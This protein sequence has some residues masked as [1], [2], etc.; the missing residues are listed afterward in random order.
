MRR[1]FKLTH[2]KDAGAEIDTE[3]LL[4]VGNGGVEPPGRELHRREKEQLTLKSK[5]LTLKS[6][7]LTLKSKA[8][9][10]FCTSKKLKLTFALFASAFAIFLFVKP[11][12]TEM[13]WGHHLQ[14]QQISNINLRN[15]TFAIVLATK[16]DRPLSAMLKHYGNECS[17]VPISTIFI[18]GGGSS[19]SS[20]G[21]D[22][23]SYGVPVVHYLPDSHSLND[24]FNPPGSSS[25]PDG[26][27]L[28]GAVLTLDDDILIPCSLL[29][30]GFSVWLSEGGI[31]GFYPRTFTENSDGTR[32][33]RGWSR[34]WY[35]GRYEMMLTKA[36]FLDVNFLTKYTN[37][38]RFGRAREYVDEVHNCEDI[39][40]NFVVGDAH[41]PTFV[42]PIYGE[43]I[44]DS[45]LFSGISSSH[46]L[47]SGIS[48][49]HTRSECLS[50]FSEVI[51][52]VLSGGKLLS[53]FDK[54]AANVW[55]WGGI[56]F[57]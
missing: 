18:V 40:M 52:D 13:Q 29:M 7:E 35:T 21:E 46:L 34:V 16:G 50:V 15:E 51:G 6:K 37:E 45:G 5:Q 1:N 32:K 44:R 19:I 25:T 3:N 27:T 30:R 48:H 24:R 8:C 17:D 54:R 12:T 2:P 43:R 47:N 23:N 41:P 38:E 9:L 55:E 53:R 28:K 4:P 33:Y 56:D 14:Q 39:L 11:C 10:C 22:L 42:S 36:S 20:S 31:V 26:S 57:F 49:M